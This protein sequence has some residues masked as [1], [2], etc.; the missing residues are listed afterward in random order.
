MQFDECGSEVESILRLWVAVEETCEHHPSIAL[1][2]GGW[3]RFLGFHPVEEAEELKW[4][5]FLVEELRRFPKFQGRNLAANYPL[6]PS[7]K[8]MLRRHENLDGN[9]VRALI[10]AGRSMDSE[11]ILTNFLRQNAD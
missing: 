1:E 8:R 11:E 2:Y 4:A 10:A 5:V 7:Y 9:Q 3:N 6:L